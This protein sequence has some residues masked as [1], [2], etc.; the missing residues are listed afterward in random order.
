L[1]LQFRALWLISLLVEW[2]DQISLDGL[3][4]FHYVCTSAF[5][6]CFRC[7]I[8]NFD[9]IFSLLCIFFPFWHEKQT[10]ISATRGGKKIAVVLDDIF[11]FFLI[12]DDSNIVSSKSIFCLKCNKSVLLVKIL[13]ELKRWHQWREEHIRGSGF[14]PDTLLIKELNR[15][16]I[17]SSL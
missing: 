10:E 2:H 3:I 9:T 6:F 16:A 13:L 5:F 4:K 7:L 15:F 11:E 12:N 8:A 14:F 17:I 1:F